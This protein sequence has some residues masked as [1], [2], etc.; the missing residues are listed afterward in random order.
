[1]E[2]LPNDIILEVKQYIPYNLLYN[3]NKTNFNKYY[4]EII[5]NYSLKNKNFKKYILNII[6]KD[7]IFQFKILINHNFT[8]WLN[9]KKWIFKNTTHFNYLEFMKYICIENNSNKCLEIL[10]KKL[11]KSC[12]KKYKNTSKNIVWSN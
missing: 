7:C 8:I 11:N 3:I 9:T 12:K 5:N 4:S 10:N 6:K 1:M 2:K